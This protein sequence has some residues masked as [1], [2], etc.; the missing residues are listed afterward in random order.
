MEMNTLNSL[1]SGAIWRAEQLEACGIPG[2]KQ[3]WMEV[4]SLEERLATLLSVSHPEGRIA[5]RGSVH[6]ALKSGDYARAQAL[7]DRYV[8]EEAAP[9]AFITQVRQI[10][11]SFTLRRG[12]RQ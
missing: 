11:G 10:L 7:V 9:E 12:R 8:A 4:S 3:A 5:R 1:V 6:A 2:V